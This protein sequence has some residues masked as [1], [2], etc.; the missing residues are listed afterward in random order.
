MTKH[1]IPE[2]KPNSILLFGDFR[3]QSFKNKDITYLFS[4]KL[5]L[6]FL[7]ILEHSR[8]GG[9]ASQHFSSI[10]WPEKE[11]DK[12][13]NLRGVII[14]HLRN[15][16]KEMEGVELI[17]DKGFFKIEIDPNL[18]YCDY[19][20]CHEIMNS[21]STNKEKKDEI[22]QILSRGKFLKLADEPCID[23]LKDSTEKLLVPF[24]LTEMEKSFCANDYHVVLILCDA[25]FN[26]DPINNEAL[27]YTVQSLTKMNFTNEARRQFYLFSTE[28]EKIMG[29]SYKT[30]YNDIV[31][32]KIK[33]AK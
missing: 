32:G 19:A 23:S 30:S 5:K 33:T 26:I 28:F 10:M 11:E 9:I 31:N 6:A 4:H 20:R 12:S 29:C 8:L 18:C 3:I 7:I 1:E 27:Y 25:L 2:I 16:F 13:K 17:Y 24:L 14:N 15:I 21:S 22:V